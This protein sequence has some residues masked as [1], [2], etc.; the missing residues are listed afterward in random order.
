MC[1]Q[2]EPV[3]VENGTWAKAD[4][5]PLYQLNP[6]A[7]SRLAEIAVPALVIA[8]A[9]DHPEILRADSLLANR[10]KEA[11]KLIPAN[12]AHVPYMEKPREFNRP[13]PGFLGCV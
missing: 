5:N 9:L 4:A 12:C 1:S 2:N 10:I 8:G 13:V 11:K 7:V 6:P 3:A